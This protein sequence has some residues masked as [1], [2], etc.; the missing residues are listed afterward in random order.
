MACRFLRLVL[1]LLVLSSLLA[2]SWAA[3]GPNHIY[4]S[5]TKDSDCRDGYLCNH[6]KCL[7]ACGGV[8]GL[9]F[10]CQDGYDC[11]DIDDGCD[12][13]VGRNCPGTCKKRLSLG[14]PGDDCG[15]PGK[16]CPALRCACRECLN[17]VDSFGC[18]NKC[19][20]VI[21]EVTGAKECSGVI[22][23]EFCPRPV[24][25]DPCDKAMGFINERVCAAFYQ[26]ACERDCG[27]DYCQT[28]YG[29]IRR[30]N[31]ASNSVW[32]PASCRR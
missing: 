3:H 21:D 29:L 7:T 30:P 31:A 16:D 28:L 5:C 26:Y 20:V 22:P 1:L 15:T 6:S 17:G 4:N 12:P 24:D 32:I 19:V 8:G 13:K 11:I 23:E 10:G 25:T 14:A 27:Q 9:Q 2:P 18:C